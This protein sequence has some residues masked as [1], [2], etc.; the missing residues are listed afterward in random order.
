MRLLPE[1]VF[2]EIGCYSEHAELCRCHE[3]HVGAAWG[4]ADKQLLPEVA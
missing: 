3:D 4:R 2:S 1:A